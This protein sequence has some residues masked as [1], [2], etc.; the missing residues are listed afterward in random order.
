M[1]VQV[2]FTWRTLHT[3]AHYLME[4]A[5]FLEAYIYICINVYERSYFPVLQIKYM[6]NEDGNLTMPFKLATGFVRVFYKNLLHMSG[7]RQ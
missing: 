5:R 4:H 2:K 1:N 6:I 7:K 3:I